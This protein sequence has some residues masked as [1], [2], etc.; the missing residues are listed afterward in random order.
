MPREIERKFLVRG[1][2][3]RRSAR[4][5]TIRQGYIAS[6]DALSVRVRKIGERAA[7]TIK[8]G[9]NSLN[10]A[11][12]E[13]DIPADDAQQ[14]LDT[15]CAPPLIEKTRYRVEHAGRTWEVDV[16]DGENEGLSVAEIELDD[17]DQ[18]F[19]RPDWAG[20]EVTDDPRYLNS[21]LARN[22][23]RAWRD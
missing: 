18:A 16:F 14:M 17:E 10:R 12:F 6:T 5:E 11:E 23:Y 9:Q 21:N 7:L 4:G 19:E 3:W 13:Y 2:G 8:S 22:P 1:D 15:L 20:D